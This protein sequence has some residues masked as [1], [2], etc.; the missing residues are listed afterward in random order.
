MNNFVIH[1]EIGQGK[2]TKVH[3]GRQKNTLKFYTLKS[4]SKNLKKFVMNEAKILKDLSHTNIIKFKNWYETRNHFWM[5]YEHVPG[6]TL[7]QIIKEDKS[8]EEKF[9]R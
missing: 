4:F 2:Y 3:K 9:L 8:I 1:N 6:S 5:I 7:A